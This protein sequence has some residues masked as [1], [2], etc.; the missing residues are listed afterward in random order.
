MIWFCTFVYFNLHRAMIA[1]FII[2]RAGFFDLNHM[3][4]IVLTSNLACYLWKQRNGSSISYLLPFL[5]ICNS[6]LWRLDAN[7]VARL[8]GQSLVCSRLISQQLLAPNNKQPSKQSESTVYRHT[9]DRISKF[10][11]LIGFSL[12]LIYEYLTRNLIT[13]QQLCFYCCC[14]CCCRIL[15]IDLS[16]KLSGDIWLS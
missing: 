12:P 3:T 14:C 10:T 8:I 2:G 1:C 5:S 6:G 9:C 11:A 13:F 7:G 16:I 15:T 4:E